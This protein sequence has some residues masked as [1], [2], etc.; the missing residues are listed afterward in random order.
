[1]PKSIENLS[2]SG[3]SHWSFTNVSCNGACDGTATANPVGGTPGYTYLWSTGAITP[4][5]TGLCPG[6]YTVTVTDANLCTNSGTVVITQPNI[7]NVSVVAS[8]LACNGDCN[9]TAV[10]TISGGTAPFAIDWTPG[11]PIGD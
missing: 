11:S 1:M 7:L 4:G 8:A 5:I 3:T 9:G 2:Y 6:S 10:A